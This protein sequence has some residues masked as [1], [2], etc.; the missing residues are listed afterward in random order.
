MQDEGVF[1]SAA[2]KS[3][4]G[5]EDEVRA[6]LRLFAQPLQ[7]TFRRTGCSPSLRGARLGILKL[8]IIAGRRAGDGR[9]SPPTT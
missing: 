2:T 6:V 5:R 9:P 7:A 1:T 8:D 4:R 3:R